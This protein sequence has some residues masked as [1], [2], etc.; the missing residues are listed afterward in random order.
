[1]VYAIPIEENW[2]IASRYIQ[3]TSTLVHWAY[4]M[5]T[6]YLYHAEGSTCTKCAWK[7]ITCDC[8]L[9]G[10]YYK[11]LRRHYGKP[12]QSIY[13]RMWK[14][15][16][17]QY[18]WVQGMKVHRFLWALVGR[19]MTETAVLVH[20]HALESAGACSKLTQG[21]PVHRKK[22]EEANPYKTWDR[23]WKTLY[24]VSM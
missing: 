12:I 8:V 18:T 3:G 23:K 22:L 6:M 13:G 4:Y 7:C 20:V 2:C 9:D 10:I 15:S 1:M 24:G 11:T 19:R 14:L 16:M 17:R 5:G 21:C